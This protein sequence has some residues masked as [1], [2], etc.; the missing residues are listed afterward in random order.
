MV[1]Y[2]SEPAGITLDASGNG[3]VQFTARKAGVL[4]VI[5]KVTLEMA[6]TSSGIVALAKNGDFLT[7]MPI[8]PKM[9]AVGDQP[10]YASEY[11]TVTITGGPVSAT[12]NVLF[13]YTERNE[14]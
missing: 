14:Q 7:S 9:T 11:L 12:V 10:L 6:T 2:K 1:G 5:R 4:T 3:S 8:G 13:F